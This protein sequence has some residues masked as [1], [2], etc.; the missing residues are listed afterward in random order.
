VAILGTWI[1]YVGMA[2]AIVSGAYWPDPRWGMMAI[3]LVVLGAGIVV[4]RKAGAP[5]LDRETHARGQ[6]AERS[7]SLTEGIRATA[8]G[9]RE[10]AE[11]APTLHLEEVKRRVEDL[12][13]LGPARL[14]E[15]QEAVSARVGFAHYAE[16]MGPLAIAERLLWRAWSA[17]SDGHRPE[18]VASLLE[19]IPYAEQA[20]AIA[21]RLLAAVKD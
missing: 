19:A 16:V 4:K 7:G 14:G 11:L 1:G 9:A 6:L 2:I 10:L 18:S 3:G 21:D 12:V 17:A 8:T 13:H 20:A 5:P 15:A